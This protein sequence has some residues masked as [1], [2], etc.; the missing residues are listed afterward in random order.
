MTVLFREVSQKK[1]GS[2]LLTC[3]V[4]A[5]PAKELFWERNGT[6]VVNSDRYQIHNWE[7]GDYQT[8]FGLF[9]T[10]LIDSDFGEYRC[11]AANDYGRAKGKITVNGIL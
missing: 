5:N 8:T 7:T 11:I 2:T 10:G 4:R 3:L 6:I 1:G 9:I